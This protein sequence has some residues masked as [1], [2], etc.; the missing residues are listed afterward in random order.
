LKGVPRA[1]SVQN[2]LENSDYELARRVVRAFLGG[3]KHLGPHDEDDLVQ[4][5]LVH[6][7]RRRHRFDPSGRATRETYLRGLAWHRLVDIWAEQ[8][9]RKRGGG[10]RPASLDQ[11]LSQDSDATLHDLVAGPR[12]HSD[13]EDTA[14]ERT[15]AGEVEELRARLSPV[16]R[17][18]LDALLGVGGRVHVASKRLGIPPS[19]AYDSL[20][21]I[22]R[23]AEDQGLREFL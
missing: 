7:W 15:L 19:T 1:P 4:E 5:V 14:W 16:D 13:V 2:S 3:S 10:M 11:P 12:A 6:W 20:K 23:I 17:V 22:R 8:H 18:V 9:A 21:R